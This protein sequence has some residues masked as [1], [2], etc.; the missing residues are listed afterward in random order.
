MHGRYLPGEGDLPLIEILATLAEHHPIST[1]GPEGVLDEVATVAPSELGA[2][3]RE[4]TEEV[5]LKA[6]PDRVKCHIRRVLRRVR[7]DQGSGFS[8]KVAALAGFGRAVVGSCSSR[9]VMIAAGGFEWNDEMVGRFLSGPVQA[10]CGTTWRQRRR[11]SSDGHGGRGGSR[12][13][14]RGMVG[15][16]G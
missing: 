13:D 8:L 1:I 7:L 3:A 9:R 14:E 12:R 5:L 10:R 11:R 4:R 15:R 16:D 6:R 2:R